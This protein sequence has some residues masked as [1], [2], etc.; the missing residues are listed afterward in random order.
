[1][2]LL[3]AIE[4]SK[5]IKDR[6]VEFC[7]D[8]R[9]VAD[10]QLR[11]I[12][13]R[14]WSGPPA[15]GGLVSQLWIEGAFPAESSADTLASLASAGLINGDLVRLLHRN[16]V[17]PE[18]RPLY[19]HQREAVL[20]GRNSRDGNRDA[21]VVS[22]PTG[23]GKTE[24][25]LLPI[26]DE[27]FS[28]ERTGLGMQCLILYPMNALVNDQVDRIEKWLEGQGSR[29][30]T[31]FHF[32]S[33]TPERYSSSLPEHDECRF[34]TRQEA[35]GLETRTGRGL[36]P[37]ETR[38]PIPDI[39]ITNYSMLEYMLCRPQDAVFFGPG[40]KAVVLDEAH[41]YTGTLAA[42]ITMLLRRLYDRCGV[43]PDKVLQIATSATLSNEDLS[44]LRAF[45]SQ[46]FSKSPQYIELIK[47][48]PAPAPLSDIEEPTAP[49]VPAQM[50]NRK[51]VTEP[52]ITEDQLVVDPVMVSN[53]VNN[54]RVIVGP[55]S[56]ERAAR[57]AQDRPAVL[58]FEAL[59]ASPIV[60]RLAE[61]L[62]KKRHLELGKLA[63]MLWNDESPDSL[64]ATLQILQIC[65]VARLLPADL[66]LLPHR[67]HL[68]VKSN[69]P[70]QV[71]LNSKCEGPL[72]N[73]LEPLGS[74]FAG[75]RD[76]CPHCSSA[77]LSLHVCGVCGSHVLAA[78][79]LDF[80][81]RPVSHL[82]AEPA[83]FVTKPVQGEMLQV[84]ISTGK[85]PSSG[86]HVTLYAVDQC[87]RCQAQ[88]QEFD[89]FAVGSPLVLTI[90]AE[91][92]L[93][94][95]PGMA[96]GL[97]DIRPAEGRRVLAFS[98]SRSEAA[99]L[100]PR[101]SVQHEVQL[102]RTAIMDALKNNPPS[103]TKTIE[104]LEDRLREYSLKLSNSNLSRAERA[105]LVG[106]KATT[107]SRLDAHRSG[108]TILELAKTLADTSELLYQVMNPDDGNLHD[109]RTW[110][111]KDWQENR[112]RVGTQT[113]QMLARECARL[114][115]LK[116]RTLEAIGLIE[117]TY[118]GVESLPIP[119]ALEDIS[120]I[121]T[122]WPN[123]L[124]FL[125]DTLREEGVV[126]IGSD[127]NDDAYEYGSE[128]IGRWA[129]REDVGYKLV[130]FVGA[131]ER[132]K[133][134]QW[135]GK[136]LIACG[137][138]QDREA[139]VLTEAFSQLL[140]EAERGTFP[141]LT[142]A[143]AK[144][145]GKSK[146][147]PA[148]RL[149]FRYLG[150]RIPQA[151]YQCA[152]TGRLWP[153][154]VNEPES[155]LNLIR[156]ESLDN[157]ARFARA[158]KEFLEEANPIFRR[159]LWAEEHSAQLSSTENRRL[160]D[161]FKGGVRNVLSA[162]TTM[163][164]GVDIGA[165]L[166]VLMSNVPPG[167]ANYLQRAGRAGR[168]SDGSS[169]VLTFA[170]QRPYDRAVFKSFGEY[171]AKP[172]RRPRMLLDRQRIVRRHIHAFLLNVF[173]QQVYPTEA[174]AGAMEAYKTFGDFCGLSF[175]GYWDSGPKPVLSPHV[176]RFPPQAS[177]LPWWST[178]PGD[179]SL[180]F[181][182][183]RFLRYL[184]TC[185]QPYHNRVLELLRGIEG[186][187]SQ[188]WVD[189]VRNV[190]ERFTSACKYWLEIYNDFEEAWK[191]DANSKASSNAIRHQMS[192]IH[193]ITTIERLADRLFLPRYGFPIGIHRLQVYQH[194]AKKER[195]IKDDRF[196]LERAGLLSLREYVPGSQLLVGGKLVTSRGLL[197]HWT[198][199]N[200]NN[201]IGEKGQLAKCA[202][203]HQ[204][205]R[206]G[207]DAI[208]ACPM[209]D[210]PAAT[211][212]MD[213]LLPRFG[214]SC[215]AWDLPRRSREVDTVGTVEQAT[216]TFVQSELGDEGER[217]EAF[218]E[219]AGLTAEYREQG[220]ILVFNRGEK[221]HGFALCL[222][223]GYADSE[224]S[225]D[226]K[227]PPKFDTHSPLFATRKE[228]KCWHKSEGVHWRHLIL[229]ARQTTDVLFIN[230]SAVFGHYAHDPT[231]AT[232]LGH[233][234]RLAGAEIL[235]IDTRE[236][237]SV[238]VPAGPSG[239]YWGILL[240]DNVPGGAG[241]VL[242]LL[243]VGKEWLTKTLQK[244]F[245]NP[246]HHE[247]CVHACLDCLLTF[248]AQHDVERGQ[249]FR[250][251]AYQVLG[252]AMGLMPSPGSPTPT[253]T[254]FSKPSEKPSTEERVH[255]AAQRSRPQKK[256]SKSQ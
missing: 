159:G 113:L 213:I 100:G 64:A 85:F 222:D 7:L 245:V 151:L 241:H 114:A 184:E 156:A 216:M 3:N 94:G 234:M 19:Q 153:R 244:M 150:I 99:R 210:Q 148:F 84:D 60:H 48:E 51:W 134:N 46:L 13:R 254:D 253:R 142:Y 193:D 41:L 44:H 206:F 175:P 247:Q 197:K 20:A 50:T 208:G 239:S 154:S 191:Q 110:S 34:R 251:R 174:A 179:Q 229:G 185:P 95:L 68:V 187:E 28:F 209:C 168:R 133:R 225:G 33:E 58:L 93:N 72:N 87:P 56:I 162:T 119:A 66:P 205:Y 16:R 90:I 57:V 171:L 180:F 24:S 81:L 117:I 75:I 8:D 47:G 252:W 122:Q 249:M 202:G 27:L 121:K 160:Q 62:W 105:L 5:T 137:F 12:C 42:E 88:A 89:S 155:T 169:L 192:V 199:A 182:F 149:D 97:G 128:L 232:T 129:S 92:L 101:L 172:L 139:S 207:Q 227:F 30:T 228:L 183:V 123:V 120:Q 25:F 49:L 67:M 158:R 212:P 65:S 152:V 201:A 11:G 203:G 55:R 243:K 37:G 59:K 163:E 108:G 116:Q 157:D 173:F 35:R 107:K 26:L 176:P 21:L 132:H 77:V 115:R 124:C 54:L 255:R 45:T 195:V 136:V 204:Y 240:Y 31:V 22:A 223:C 118:P 9:F 167:K 177:G 17:F 98:D 220:E 40:L 127:A 106:D 52:T 190:Q 1:M 238:A 186:W 233:A 102:V 130:R 164:L 221:G 18:D 236:V 214:F 61:I 63:N 29:R 86:G 23:A 246:Q 125:L 196:R 161:L 226:K 83:L 211:R 111:L 198:G 147:C 71:C 248:D 181:Q 135:V 112:N 200:M 178:R 70:I 231:I 32:T 14:I 53:L 138:T 69:D 131:T 141:W 96:G 126:T 6:L 235:D 250:L 165:L 104:L 38:G 224:V 109:A 219:V 237:G 188:P 73:R 256:E 218:G 230:P 217:V 143:S 79:R 140:A 36:R 74:V 194:D 10:G 170:R 76:R 103:D 15:H 145:S 2:Q 80:E 146:P 166:A 215:A 82:G 91:T 43:D 242:E 4:L 189:L 39:V 78:E 144:L